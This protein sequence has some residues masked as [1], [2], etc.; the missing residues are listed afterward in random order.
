MSAYP[1]L[2]ARY[3]GKQDECVLVRCAAD[4][5]E[6]GKLADLDIADSLLELELACAGNDADKIADAEEELLTCYAVF[7]AATRETN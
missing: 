6:S 2:R 5:V 4:E 3:T 7:I 1:H